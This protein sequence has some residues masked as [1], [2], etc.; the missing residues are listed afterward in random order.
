MNT[1]SAKN[2][3]VA[4]LQVMAVLLVEPNLDLLLLLHVLHLAKVLEDAVKHALYPL[5]HTA[6]HTDQTFT[7]LEASTYTTRGHH[8]HAIVDIP[9]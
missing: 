7:P 5:M 1:K 6:K 8:A 2:W 9:G 3:P 4:A